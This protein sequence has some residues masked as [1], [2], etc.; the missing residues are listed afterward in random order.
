[1]VAIIIRRATRKDYQDILTIQKSGYGKVCWGWPE[2]FGDFIIFKGQSYVV[3][4]DD[5]P[6]GYL[7][8]KRSGLNTVH[9]NQICFLAEY[10][11]RGLGTKTLDWVKNY[12]KNKGVKNLTLH[13][14][15]KK[16]INIKWYQSQ[17]FKIQ[18][19][20]RGYY[21][22]GDDAL[23]MRYILNDYKTT[24]SIN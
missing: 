2:M 16:P 18:R 4:E 12:A 14:E 10:Q 7:H 24:H 9:I 19:R 13:V 3:V 23:F 20:I 5:K 6:V 11:Q 22:H 21:N 17:G 8:I 1:M 15:S